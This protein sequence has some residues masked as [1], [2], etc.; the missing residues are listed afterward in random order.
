M[1]LKQLRLEGPS[2]DDLLA[3]VFAVHGPLAR[4]VAAEKV[5]VGGIRGFFARSHFE[6]TVDV[7]ALLGGT[8][9]GAAGSAGDKGDARDGVEDSA[10]ARDSA[11]DS[12][13][14]T[15][16]HVLPGA[17]KRAGLVSLLEDAERDEA[18]FHPAAA[19]P[20]VSTDSDAF[21]VLMDDLT[22]NVFTPVERPVP[23]SSG[24]FPA[25]TAP[26][27]LAG[28][29]DLVVCAGVGADSIPAAV[30]L[31]DVV[32]LS[33]VVLAGVLEGEGRRI[34]NRRTAA[35]ARARGV[36]RG[37]SITVAF[38]LGPGADVADGVA[39]L[40]GLE[41]DQVWL[42]IDAG[43]KP[44]DTAAWVAMVRAALPVAGLV[45]QGAGATQTPETVER[46]GLP[47]A[48]IDG[49]STRPAAPGRHRRRGIE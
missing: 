11:S 45:V 37:E 14:A 6:V 36:Q 44:A 32:G 10:S 41:P 29:G 16:G 27:V 46:L 21:A 1:A 8:A 3:Q 24:P 22:F 18:R 31:G 43:R 35:Q 47:I 28:A 4:I 38:G 13:S 19:P 25:L 49:K 12:A 34:E 23:A 20:L 33:A 39:Q 40:A 30:L 42:V 17:R 5:M 48:F 9:V 26:P 15:G 2:L 7:P